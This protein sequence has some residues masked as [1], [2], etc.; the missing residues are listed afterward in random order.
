[1]RATAYERD[2]ARRRGRSLARADVTRLEEAI[3]DAAY[4]LESASAAEYLNP[5]GDTAEIEAAER[6]MDR[7]EGELR[8]A[9][10]ALAHFAP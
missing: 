8:R 6:Q 7:L 10:A 1:M 2:A 9:Q 3:R 5:T 4:A